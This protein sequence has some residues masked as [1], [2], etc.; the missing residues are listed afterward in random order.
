[1]LK[2][3]QASRS[4]GPSGITEEAETLFCLFV[5]VFVFVFYF[6]KPLNFYAT[7]GLPP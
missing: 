2:V 4:K 3:A 1:M 7:E 6:L 5:F